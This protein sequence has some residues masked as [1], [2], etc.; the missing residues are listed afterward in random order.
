MPGSQTKQLRRICAAIVGFC[1]F[2]L[3]TVV[4]CQHTHHSLHDSATAD[5]L[6][7]RG[8]TRSESTPLKA[9]VKASSKTPKA[10]H[11]AACEWQASSASP[12]IPAFCLSLTAPRAPSFVANLPRLLSQSA[13]SGSSRAPPLA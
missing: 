7:F 3:S 4:A 12:A 9:V 11:C 13:P 8:A 1:Y 10:T 5:V 2:W 6:Q